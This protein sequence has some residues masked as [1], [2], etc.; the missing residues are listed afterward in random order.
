MNIP[1]EH[2][3]NNSYRIGSTRVIEEFS[4]GSRTGKTVT[5]GPFDFKVNESAEQ[6]YLLVS[7]WHTYL[8]QAYDAVSYL[9]D[10]DAV[11]LLGDPSPGMD[12]EEQA[13]TY[14][15]EFAGR[16]SKGEKPVVYVRGNHE[17]RGNFASYL[18]GYLGY[19][20]LYYSADFG[21]YSFVVLDSGED[22]PDDHIEYGGMTD[23]YT[24]R[25]RMTEWFD[26]FE[27]HSDKIIVLSHAWQVSEP[28]EELSAR[29]WD[30][31]K[32]IGARA[33]LSGHTHECRFIDG[34]NEAEEAHLL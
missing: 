14:L 13:V 30:R 27:P 7:D 10:Y 9:G 24:N 21:P 22:K 8:K 2:L 18:P 25:L 34:R 31:I 15:V 17:T 29:A 19:E 20:K 33:V 32:E 1:Y 28:E 16:L 23:Y 5:A 26:S 12:F 11:L 4:Y 6:S 3:R